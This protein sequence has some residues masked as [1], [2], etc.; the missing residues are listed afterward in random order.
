MIGIYAITN[1]K[2]KEKYI[3]Q[4][5]NIEMRISGHRK[6]LVKGCHHNKHLQSSFNKY[7]PK[8]FYFEVIEECD[9][10]ELTEREQYWIDQLSPKFNKA[11][12]AG[13]TAGLKLSA[14]TR[15]KISIANI[16]REITWGD[17]ISKAKKGVR[18]TTKAQLAADK[19][20]SELRKGKIGPTKGMKI[21][22]IS[23]A[24]KKIWQERHQTKK[25][26]KE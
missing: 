11:P 19:R 1:L 23:I 22:N 20:Q 10:E 18:H 5:S 2:T 6:A 21:P 16:G 24:M 8:Y 4:S 17:K 12:A 3:G 13:S 14:S 7:G 9:L 25:M 15:L 26:N